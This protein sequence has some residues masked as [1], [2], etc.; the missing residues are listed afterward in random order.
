MQVWGSSSSEAIWAL[1]CWAVVVP[2]HLP[3][4]RAFMGSGWTAGASIGTGPHRGRTVPALTEDSSKERHG[5]AHPWPSSGRRQMW[6]SHLACVDIWTLPGYLC[7]SSAYQQTDQTRSFQP[8][9]SDLWGCISLAARSWATELSPAI[10][11][12][13]LWQ[14]E[15]EFQVPVLYATSLI[16]C[17]L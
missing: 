5:L 11:F 12:V 15:F 6:G 7:L 1:L 13:I 3:G 16:L 10:P 2:A 17:F 8:L 9:R 4:C 14:D